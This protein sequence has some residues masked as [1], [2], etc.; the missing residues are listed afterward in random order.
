MGPLII[1][2]N[3]IILFFNDFQDQPYPIHE[4][5]LFDLSSDLQ[6]NLQHFKDPTK[7]VLVTKHYFLVWFLP[8]II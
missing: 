4:F 1:I 2:N 7:K 5:L 8:Q 3:K 6:L